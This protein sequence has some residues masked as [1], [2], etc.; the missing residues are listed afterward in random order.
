MSR[1]LSCII[2][3]VLL[4]SLPA[5][6]VDYSADGWSA[7]DMAGQIAASG[8][9]VMYGVSQEDELYGEYVD[10]YYGISRDGLEDGAVFAAGGSSAQEVAVFRFSDAELAEAASVDLE[11]Y[12]SEREAAFAGYM[13]EEADMVNNA[14]V[15]VRGNWCALI[16]LPDAAAGVG[17]FDSCFENPP[18]AEISG[19]AEAMPHVGES[20]APEAGTGWT[21]SEQRILDAYFT[22]NYSGL[23][24]YDLAILDVC[25]HVL[26]AVAPERMSEYERELAIHDYIIRNVSYD[27]ETLS[28]L[29]F[30]DENPNNTNPYG[31]LVD[32]RAVCLGYS[33]SFQ[34]FMDLIGVECITV[35]GQGN[36]DREEHAWNMVKLEGEWYCV[37]VTWDDPTI[38]GAVSERQAHRYFNVTSDFMRDTNHFWDANGVPEATGTQYAWQP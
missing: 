23:S 11:N 18:P 14:S 4:L 7:E 25:D 3:I 31:A 37:D 34:L 26:T 20:P 22:G 32:G 5:C 28:I 1:T 13:P 24:E 9:Q 12:L 17:I 16:I 21:Y 2:A 30:F 8:P 15:V 36:A 38:M 33:S 29:P 19:D 35:H 27:S 10:V 6:G